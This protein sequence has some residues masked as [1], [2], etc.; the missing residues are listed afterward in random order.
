MLNESRKDKTI[1][2]IRD[3]NDLIV[4]DVYFILLQFE[5][6]DRLLRYT[7]IIVM[8]IISFFYQWRAH[9]DSRKILIIISHR[10]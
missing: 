5:I 3:L 7:H 4:F 6:I 1:V 8:N 2:D 10:K 9:L